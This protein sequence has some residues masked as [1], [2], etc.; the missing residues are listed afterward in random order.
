M[1]RVSNKT[2]IN[3][4]IKQLLIDYNIWRLILYGDRDWTL[5]EIS[6][7][8]NNGLVDED[9]PNRTRAVRGIRSREKLQ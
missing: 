2:I 1:D 8:R 3:K 6:E 5:G 9:P 4:V 7:K